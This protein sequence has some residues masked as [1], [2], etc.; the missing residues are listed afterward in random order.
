MREIR[1]AVDEFNEDEIGLKNDRN[2]RA[3]LL[4]SI[5][6]LIT[7]AAGIPAGLVAILVGV[8]SRRQVRELFCRL[9]SADATSADGPNAKCRDFC[10]SAALWG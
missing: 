6:L 5:F 2:H 3:S 4:R 9:C 10:F 1:S 8:A 7:V